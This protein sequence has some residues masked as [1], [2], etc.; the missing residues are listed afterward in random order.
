MQGIQKKPTEQDGQPIFTTRPC[1]HSWFLNKHGEIN[2]L[3]AESTS[4]WFPILTGQPPE[5]F[6][7]TKKKRNQMHNCRMPPQG[8]WR[9]SSP[10][11]NSGAKN[12]L[13]VMAGS[14]TEA[15]TSTFPWADR[16]FCPQRNQC[17]WD[18]CMQ[19]APCAAR[20]GSCSPATLQGYSTPLINLQQDS[21]PLRGMIQ[22]KTLKYIY[23][24]FCS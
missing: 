18:G 17:L 5:L 23:L 13:R 14:A 21:S 7:Q 1:Q 15:A 2:L 4:A 19:T 3:L 10:S 24:Y 6:K 11:F 9:V 16:S 8:Y 12:K 22:Q 20:M